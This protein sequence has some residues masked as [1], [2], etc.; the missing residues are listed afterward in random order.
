MDQT[1]VIGTFNP[2]VEHGW[3]NIKPSKC[4]PNAKDP[5]PL[6]KEEKEK[7]IP[8]II[9]Y[10]NDKPSWNVLGTNLNLPLPNKKPFILQSLNPFHVN[11]RKI[12]QQ[13]M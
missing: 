7:L 10:I 6:K 3:K 8:L 4:L 1:M 11:S 13:M 12:W 2:K 5:Y 9:I